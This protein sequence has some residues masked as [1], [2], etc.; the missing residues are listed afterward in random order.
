MQVQKPFFVTS[1]GD[2]NK[3]EAHAIALQQ[4]GKKVG[5]NKNA[6]GQ[7]TSE[8]PRRLAEPKDFVKTHARGFE[9]AD[10]KDM[11]DHVFRMLVKNQYYIDQ[12]TLEEARKKE[13]AEQLEQRTA[14]DKKDAAGKDERTEEP[15][16]FFPIDVKQLV[17]YENLEEM[18]H[19][20]NIVNFY[21]EATK[22]EVLARAR[23]APAPAMKASLNTKGAKSVNI[24]NLNPEI[25]TNTIISK[26]R[27]GMDSLKVPD[28]AKESAFV[29]GILKIINEKGIQAVS[30]EEMSELKSIIDSRIKLLRAMGQQLRQEK[31]GSLMPFG[32]EDAEDNVMGSDNQNPH[33]KNHH[34]VSSIGSLA[35]SGLGIP[36]E[37][38][39]PGG[40][41]IY[42]KL[43]S[44]NSSDVFSRIISPFP[45]RTAHGSFGGAEHT[46]GSGS[47]MK[48]TLNEL[49]KAQENLRN[50]MEG[51]GRAHSMLA[52]GMSESRAGDGDFGEVA[53]EKTPG[54]RA[55]QG[56]GGP[57]TPVHARYYFSSSIL[58]K[59]L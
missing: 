6:L 50:M 36:G 35:T 28:F 21:E 25:Q 5:P 15:E 55:S 39:T 47:K 18:K 11:F 27:V 3:S 37:L 19:L 16:E 22:Q 56:R 31:K 46:P 12:R 24:I 14:G 33:R 59:K 13:K 58:H 41:A 51:H 4:L 57:T 44:L 42:E 40:N 10:N 38:K 17:L 54:H 53:A 1:K 43:Q 48:E 32:Q 30:L 49:A 34:K 9:E 29:D 23:A 26:Y 8:F 7:T 20:E 2:Y 52:G 45:G